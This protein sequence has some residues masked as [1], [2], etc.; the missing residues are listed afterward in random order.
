MRSAWNSVPED[1]TPKKGPA[2]STFE[3][4]EA[5]E[6]DKALGVPRAVAPPVEVDWLSE[7]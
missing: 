7:E 1:D 2:F 3:C 5:K 6:G 4:H